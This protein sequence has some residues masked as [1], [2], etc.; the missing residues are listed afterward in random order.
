R[1]GIVH[2]DLKPGNVMLTKS[3]VKLL[4][5]G[6]AKAMAPAQPQSAL[7]SGP[8]EAGSPKMTQEG[9]ILGTFQYM[10]PEQ[11]E[12]TDADARTDI[13]SLG[14]VFYEMAT[15]KRAYQGGSMTSL[16]AAIVSS[17]PAPIKMMVPVAPAALDHV[18]RRCLEKDPADRW[19]SARRRRRAAMDCRGGLAGGCD[20]ADHDTAQ[21]A[22]SDGV[23]AG[24]GARIGRAGAGAR[25]P[26]AAG[27]DGDGP[28]GVSRHA[29][30]ATGQRAHSVRPAGPD[31]VAGWQDSGLRRFRR[32]PPQTNLA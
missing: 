21:D 1:Q 27:T 20:R 17:Q 11:L 13:F 22:R 10:A 4:D 5:F 24:G 2:R 12:G 19:Q 16:I 18:V 32:R 14:T 3:G 6:L 23:G 9:T 26:V 8:T 31:A 25:H 15:G 29:H 28:A 7:T 30:A